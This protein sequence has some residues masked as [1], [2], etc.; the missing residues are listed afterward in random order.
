MYIS[1]VELPD[2]N[3]TLVLEG[4]E[5]GADGDVHYMTVDQDLDQSLEKPKDSYADEG[6]NQSINLILF[7]IMQLSMLCLCIYVSGVEMKP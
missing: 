6:K 3:Y 2:G 4:G 5:E 7:K 1:R